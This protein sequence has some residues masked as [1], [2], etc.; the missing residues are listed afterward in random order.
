MSNY[1][2][3]QSLDEIINEVSKNKNYNKINLFN[4]YLKKNK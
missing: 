4:I 2:S 1:N 3:N